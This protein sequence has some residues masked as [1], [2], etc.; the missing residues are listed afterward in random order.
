GDETG[1]GR[2]HK[3]STKYLR[4]TR[5]NFSSVTISGKSPTW[6]ARPGLETEGKLGVRSTNTM[7]QDD[8]QKPD[9]R[10]TQATPNQHNVAAIGAYRKECEWSQRG[11]TEQDEQTLGWV[12]RAGIGVGVYTL[13][14]LAAV[15]L[16]YCAP[17]TSLDTEQR[18]LRAYVLVEN[19]TYEKGKLKI[20]LK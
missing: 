17:R 11:G 8:Q 7:T 4:S 2:L 12:K 6:S 14:T 15:I 3:T 18:Q 10:D 1:K 9:G 19:P 5:P 20:T 13:L 16:T